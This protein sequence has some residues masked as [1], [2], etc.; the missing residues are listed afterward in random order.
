[1]FFTILDQ[2]S[3][4][5][6]NEHMSF[7]SHHVS[8]QVKL[9]VVRTV[10]GVHLTGWIM[11]GGGWGCCWGCLSHSSV[12]WL[13]CVRWYWTRPTAPCAAPNW[14]SPLCA[15]IHCEP[16]VWQLDL[17]SY[18][19]ENSTLFHYLPRPSAGPPNPAIHQARQPFSNS[20][21]P[22]AAVKQMVSL[23]QHP[24]WQ[25]GWGVCVFE[26][27]CPVQHLLNTRKTAGAADRRN[28]KDWHLMLSAESANT[29]RYGTALF[30]LFF[31]FFRNDY[32]STCIFS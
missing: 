8:S 12:S 28:T 18:P 30:V 27:Q 15:P 24:H 19:S 2:K 14:S 13:D 9:Q 5:T 20:P 6:W 7:S 25:A 3:N 17:R 11:M 29:L 1:M 31:F 4:L 21:H 10:T 23:N 26:A 16:A 32:F 22:E